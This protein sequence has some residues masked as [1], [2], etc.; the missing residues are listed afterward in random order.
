MNTV[1]VWPYGCTGVVEDEVPVKPA[2]A[3]LV[4]DP[5]TPDQFADID[6][7]VGPEEDEEDELEAVCMESRYLLTL[8]A[9]GCDG[10]LVGVLSDVSL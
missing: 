10:P 8:S 9:N 1:S 4:S 2:P 7:P 3:P 6:V 5:V